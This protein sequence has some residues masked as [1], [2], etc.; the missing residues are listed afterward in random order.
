MHK[1]LINTHAFILRGC[2][3]KPDAGFTDELRLSHT[4]EREITIKTGCMWGGERGVYNVRLHYKKSFC[5][6]LQWEGR[7]ARESRHSQSRV[8]NGKCRVRKKYI[9]YILSMAIGS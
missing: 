3:R 7:G 2:P 9:Q 5:I 1:R 8:Q 6:G 4:D